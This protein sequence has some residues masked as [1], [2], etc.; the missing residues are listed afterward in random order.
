M[1]M[2][3]RSDLLQLCAATGMSLALI[4]GAGAAFAKDGPVTVIGPSIE[5]AFHENVAYADLALASHDGRQALNRR[6]DAAV[7]RVCSFGRFAPMLSSDEAVN[8]ARTAW[9]NAQPQVAL[10][11]KR[12]QPMAANGSSAIPLTAITISATL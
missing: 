10:A 2:L 8:C 5:Q 3:T 1:M 11:V 7:A 6:V 9:L 12:S 4:A